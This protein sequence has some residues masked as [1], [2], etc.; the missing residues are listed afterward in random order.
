[1]LTTRRR[2]RATRGRLRGAE[3]VVEVAAHHG[4]G[5]GFDTL[6]LHRGDALLPGLA[7]RFRIA[8]GGI[9]QH[10][11]AH[12]RRMAQRQFLA[13]H[14]AHRQADPHHRAGIEFAQQRGGVVGQVGHA[15]GAGRR[16]RAAVA[17]MVV[18]DHA[19]VLRQLIG[20]RVPHGQV[21]A[22][23]WLSTTVWRGALP[24]R[25]SRTL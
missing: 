15:V 3:T 11:R 8:R 20:Q 1:V 12:Q 14:A 7:R 19:A 10:Q 5:D 22:E 13:D 4:V 21:A 2:K 23:A 6:C 18:G 9:R 25:G 24:L 16:L 17:A